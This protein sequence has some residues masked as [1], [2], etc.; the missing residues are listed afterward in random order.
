MKTKHFIT[1]M[2]GF[3]LLSC[4]SSRITSSWK[5]ET[6]TAKTYKKI[7]VLGL[8]READRRIQEDMEEH[9]V[10]DLAALG[11][12]AVGSLKEYGAKFF[13]NKDEKEA[14][15]KIAESNIDAVITIVLLDKQKEHNYVPGRIYYSP[16]NVYYNRF[17]GYR[18]T[19]YNRIYEPGYYVTDTKYFWESNLYD[20]SNQQLVYSVQTQSFRSD[21]SVFLG[22]EYGLLIV[23]DMVKNHVLEGTRQ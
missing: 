16:Y 5:A 3:L 7:L 12:N 21:N 2:I 17:W 8:I 13:D 10:G 19:L 15:K 23:K 11:F 4:S 9:M 14:L 20:M 18:T 22:H 1:A 6:Y